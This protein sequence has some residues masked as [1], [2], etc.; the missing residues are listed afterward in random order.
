[1]DI[2]SKLETSMTVSENAIDFSSH[3]SNQSF[4][5]MHHEPN[6][7][8]TSCEVGKKRK[9]IA[10]PKSR[11][12]Y[13]NYYEEETPVEKKT[14]FQA[15]K[16]RKKY[17]SYSGGKTPVGRNTRSQ[18]SGIITALSANTSNIYFA[19]AAPLNTN[20]IGKPSP[21]S[22]KS[23]SSII[24]DSNFYMCSVRGCLSTNKSKLLYPLPPEPD[25]ALKWLR[26]LDE[27]R[28]AHFL[29]MNGNVPFN[30]LVC[31]KH[32]EKNLF[33]KDQFC[34]KLNKAGIPT[35]H[36]PS[37]ENN[38]EEYVFDEKTFSSATDSAGNILT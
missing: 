12:K 15:S 1:M 21:L 27:K 28:L 14:R 16:S 6:I 24:S 2:S 19:A 3:S 9:G 31:E 29:K 35:K 20:N 32:F 5:A 10:C 23:H 17:K 11:K 13:V 30:F 8:S 4:N 38:A 25:L 36:L 26:S 22:K 18:T 33:K 37:S 7:T 34:K